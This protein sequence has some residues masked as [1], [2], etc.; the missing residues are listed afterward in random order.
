MALHGCRCSVDGMPKASRL[1]TASLGFENAC[2]GDVVRIV[3]SKSTRLVCVVDHP[4]WCFIVVVAG[5]AWSLG[6]VNDQM[7]MHVGNEAGEVRFSAGKCCFCWPNCTNRQTHTYSPH[8][9]T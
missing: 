5:G 6:M 7:D 1:S 3:T 8:L 4:R 2:V 9:F